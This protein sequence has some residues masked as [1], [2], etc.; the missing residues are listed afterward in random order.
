MANR[1][2]GQFG[3]TRIAIWVSATSVRTYTLGTVVAQGHCYVG[4]RSESEEEH[5]DATLVLPQVEAVWCGANELDRA[6][7]NRW[8]ELRTGATREF[9]IFTFPSAKFCDVSLCCLV[10]QL[11]WVLIIRVSV[12]CLACYIRCSE[13][14]EGTSTIPVLRLQRCAEVY[15]ST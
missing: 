3:S 13:I 2:V 10:C 11:C 6:N 14:F 1:K 7:T 8:N 12:L 5:I 4:R 9:N 15:R